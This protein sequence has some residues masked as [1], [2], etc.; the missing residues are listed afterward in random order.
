MLH[1]LASPFFDIPGNPLPERATGGFMTA[2][3]GL[4]LRFARFA[5]TGRPLKGTVIILPGRN[6]CIEKY[7]ETIRDFSARGLGSAIFDWRGQ[8]N[9]GRLLRDPARGYVDSF[10]DYVRDIEQLFEEIVLPDCRAPFYILGHSTGSLVALLAAPAMVNR[11]RRMVLGVPPLTLAGFPFS[12]PT[13][14]GIANALYSVGLGS[15]YMA[16]GPRPRETRPFSTNVLTTDLNRYRR[17]CLLYETYPELAL[18]GPTV[19]W[20]RAACMASATVQ[21]PDYI[22]R[23]QIPML[24]VAAGSD[25][26][27]STA[28]IERF[29]WQIKSASLLTI[30]GARHEI[31]QEADIYREQLL[32]AFEAFV[33][34]NDPSDV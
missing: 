26:I 21:D 24:F 15:M 1:T 11:V 31:W 7:F 2:R 22:A 28:A 34:G 32:A 14:R 4:R 8:G 13:I 25:A 23:L 9:S 12:M 3:D 17:N 20:V 16:G 33:P 29:V 27:V 30:D 19:A 5:A 10:Y 6:E 18:G